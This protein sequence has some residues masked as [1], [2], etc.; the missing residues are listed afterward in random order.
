[1]PAGMFSRQTI[2]RLKEVFDNIFASEEGKKRT[3]KS[4][5]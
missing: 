4:E 1:M 3:D 5:N 2:D